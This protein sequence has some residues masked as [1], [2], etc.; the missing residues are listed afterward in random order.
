MH[1]VGR[2][3]ANKQQQT[4][5]H[6]SYLYKTQTR[7]NPSPDFKYNIQNPSIQHLKSQDLESNL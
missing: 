3:L 2:D 4:K 7:L 1:R 5:Q 6:L